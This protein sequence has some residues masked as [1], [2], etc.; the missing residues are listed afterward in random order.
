MKARLRAR[1]RSGGALGGGVGSRKGGW[2]GALQ[3]LA[4]LPEAFLLFAAVYLFWVAR[5]F[6]A[7]VGGGLGPGFWPRLLCAGIVLV[8]GFRLAC[9]LRDRSSAGSE[10]DAGDRLAWRPVVLVSGLT[11]GYVIG[12][13][14]IGYIPATAIFVAAFCYLGGARGWHLVPLGAAAALVLA[15]LFLRV[16]YLSLP[17]GV[18]VFDELSVFL[19]RVLG[20]S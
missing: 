2:R 7:P 10:W 15:Y 9:K 20:V 1:P 19:Y 11:A 13:V 17:S 8:C 16:V 5:G 4:L 6:E 12:A 18:G 14:V 3:A